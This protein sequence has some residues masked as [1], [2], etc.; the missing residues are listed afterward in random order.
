M[1][2]ARRGPRPSEVRDN[3]YRGEGRVRFSS[4]IFN[5]S[6]SVN[7]SVGA[8]E[9]LNY[10]AGSNCDHTHARRCTHMCGHAVVFGVFFNVDL[11]FAD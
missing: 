1:P 8:G 10:S 9:A 6:P 7:V 11:I 4:W 3:S 5:G 2:T